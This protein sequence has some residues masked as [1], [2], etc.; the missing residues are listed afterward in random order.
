MRVNSA[1]ST[2]KVIGLLLGAHSGEALGASFEFGPA[3]NPD[4]FQTEIIGGG[5]FDWEPGAATD[6][7]D[8]MMCLLRS[9][10]SANDFDHDDLARKFVDWY[11][12][13]PADIG[14]TVAPALA[15]MSEGKTPTECGNPT[16]SAQGNGSLMRCAPISLFFE[17]E[18]LERVAR[19]QCVFT[20]G[21][22]TC[23]DADVIFLESL[24]DC[25]KG[26]SKNQ[27][28]EKA[29]LRAEELNADLAEYFHKLQNIEWDE[30]PTSGWVVH[31]LGAAYWALLQ[32]ESFEEGV[33]LIA[34]KGDDSD[35]CACVTGALLGAWYGLKAIPERWIETLQ[36]REEIKTLLGDL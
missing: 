21:S 16:E 1:I 14:S 24:H 31:T 7:M 15:K 10:T 12:T 36:Y 29:K 6:D 4:N 3:N 9:F 8:M 27:I 33:I 17:G 28:F 19:E 30:L 11:E 34:N 26:L 35:T 5:P 18:S 32:S 13:E 22:S 23:Q 2:D 25:F 20:H